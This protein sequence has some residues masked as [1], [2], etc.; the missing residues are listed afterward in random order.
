MTNP[1]DPSITE[2]ITKIIHFITETTGKAPT[3]N[4]LADSLKRYFV[5]NEIRDHI[6]MAR[7]DCDLQ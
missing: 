4:E 6:L 5:M 3:V 2:A 1:I 7:R